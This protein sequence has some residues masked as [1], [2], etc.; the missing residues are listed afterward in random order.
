MTIKSFDTSDG[1][2]PIPFKVGGEVFHAHSEVPVGVLLDFASV[3]TSDPEATLD[4]EEIV[5]KGN[6]TL[7][8]VIRFF[9]T[10]LVEEDLPRFKAL[11]RNPRKFITLQGLVEI[12][13]WLAEQQS[14]PTG[15]QSPSTSQVSRTGPGSTAG[16]SRKVTT[17]SR[18][19][20]VPA[21]LST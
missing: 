4:D 13:E 14:N 6:E 19:D 8:A 21:A 3:T 18:P 15:G 7:A 16:R 9:D 1:G 17:Y 12:A 10:A 5:S 2:K 11:L 20:K